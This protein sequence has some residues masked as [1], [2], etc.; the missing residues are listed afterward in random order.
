MID[1]QP[2][3]TK[4]T[5]ADLDVTPR[6][7][8]FDLADA[9]KGHWLGGDPVGTAVFNALSLTFPD[10]EI[11]TAQ[12]RAT[13]ASIQGDSDKKRDLAIEAFLRCLAIGGLGAETAAARMELENLYAT[14]KNPPLSVDAA[15]LQKRNE[16][17][18]DAP[19]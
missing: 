6:D 17:G 19:R 16:M 10:G 2:P 13:T 4:S 11:S 14:L 7:I 1:T 5:P 15:V 18:L 9:Q 8:R 12:V 3:Q